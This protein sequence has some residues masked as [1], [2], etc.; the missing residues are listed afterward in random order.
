MRDVFRVFWEALKD[1]WDELFLLALMNAV[2]VLLAIPVITFPPALAGLWSVANRVV[3]GMATG[4]RDYF[5]GF[6]RY[7]WKAWG[8][9]LLN[10]LVTTIVLTSIRFYTPGNA[11]FEINPTLSLWIRAFWVVV[12][13]LWMVFQMY[14]LALLLE[15]E[16]QRLRTALRNAAALL[17]AN[18]GF[19]LLLAV[20]LLITAVISTVFPALWFLVTVALFAVVC[21]K[22]VRHLLQPYREQAQAQTNTEEGRA[23][24]PSDKERPVLNGAE[25]PR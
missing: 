2:T 13:L 16:D 19:T 14:P 20:L 15:Q 1:F 5:A 25:G 4:W 22:A 6:R 17:I 3:Q 23:E 11:P 18:P 10:I 8:L 24:R 7:F 12:A 9:A 21:N